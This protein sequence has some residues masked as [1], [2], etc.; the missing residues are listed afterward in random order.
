MPAVIDTAKHRAL[1]CG[2]ISLPFN[3]STEGHILRCR[4]TRA[5]PR[6]GS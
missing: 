4:R 3:D 2:L 1:G 5:R 6:G